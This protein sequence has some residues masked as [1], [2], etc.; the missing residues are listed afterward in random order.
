MATLQSG[1]PTYSGLR[2]EQLPVCIS[3]DA[4]RIFWPLDG[5]FP[6]AIS[7]MKTLKS[8]DALEPY[9]GGD[10]SGSGSDSDSNGTWHAISQ[11]SL[12]EPEISSITVSVMDFEHWEETWLDWHREHLEEPSRQFVLD[13]DNPKMRM[14]EDGWETDSDDEGDLVTCCNEER[15]VA[16]QAVKLVVNP[17]A[18]REF[19]TIHDYLSAVHPWLISLRGEIMKA[20]AQQLRQQLP[21]EFMVRMQ[22]PDQLR[23]DG[24]ASWLQWKN[25]RRVNK[26]ELFWLPK[27]PKNEVKDVPVGQ[28]I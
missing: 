23:I 22:N 17:A 18:G 12:T 15:P 20:K 9:F 28:I 4:E 10:T 26:G 1:Y 7:V 19:V 2:D 3:P 24:K 25:P 8:T 11:L 21:T 14:I 5:V 27:E 13:E 6:T 16:K